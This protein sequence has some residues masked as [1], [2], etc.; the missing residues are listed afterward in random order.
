MLSENCHPVDTI[1]QL[2]WSCHSSAFSSIFNAFAS[3]PGMLSNV[4]SDAI[5]LFTALWW[6][7]KT[8]FWEALL[9]LYQ[10]IRLSLRGGQGT[11]G[12]P[13]GPV[14]LPFFGMSTQTLAFG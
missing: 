13:R 7:L 14:G 10:H 4:D 5:T 8:V 2:K 1:E 11:A 12:I 6:L 9:L 3:Q